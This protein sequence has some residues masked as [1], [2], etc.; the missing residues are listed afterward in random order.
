MAGSW[1]ELILC[2]EKKCMTETKRK[3]TCPYCNAKLE[4][5]ECTGGGNR[6]TDF[7]EILYCKRCGKEIDKTTAEEF[8]VLYDT[9]TA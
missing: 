1:R 6:M 4:V 5:V 3:I 8:Q 2:E 7:P 9:P